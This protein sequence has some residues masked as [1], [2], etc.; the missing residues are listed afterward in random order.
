VDY[1]T[2]AAPRFSDLLRAALD[3]MES[4]A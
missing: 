3:R 4:N 2:S 1:V